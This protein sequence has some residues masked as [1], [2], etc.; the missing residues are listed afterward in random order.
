MNN[1]G[2][3]VEATKI[4]T[5]A[6]GAVVKKKTAAGIKITDVVLREPAASRIGK[7]PGRYIT[8]EGDRELP[9]MALFIE[10]ALRELI[11]ESGRI[12]AAGLGNPNVT[13]DSLGAICARKIVPR[14]DRQFSVAA[15]ETDVTAR[16]G[17]DTA[18]LVRAAARE[19]SADCVIA[20][21]ALACED[22]QRIGKTVQLS[23]TGFVLGSGAGNDCGEISRSFLRIPTVSVGVPTMTALA[24]LTNKH[25]GDFLVTAADIDLITERWAEVIADGINGL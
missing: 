25:K 4:L 13:H 1:S 14:N 17:I 8:L 23:D 22:P 5:E 2:L 3:A 9:Q 15:M 10:K 20:I 7:L 12:F 6:D 16:T 21:D 18:R 11:C 19:I 24:S